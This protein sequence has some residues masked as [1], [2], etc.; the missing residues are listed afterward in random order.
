MTGVI[1]SGIPLGGF[2]VQ[3][4]SPVIPSGNRCSVTG[5]L[6]SA[7][8]NPSDTSTAYCARSSFVMPSSG[9]ISRSGLE[10]RTSRTPSGPPGT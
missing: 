5:R 7:R 1:Q 9:Q 8:M 3:N 2:L 4:S 6:P 10:I